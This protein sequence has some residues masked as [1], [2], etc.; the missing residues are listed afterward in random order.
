MLALGA[1]VLGFLGNTF[2]E[3]RERQDAR[4]ALTARAEVPL[5]AVWFELD[6]PVVAP[7]NWRQVTQFAV[8]LETALPE[9]AQEAQEP[10]T[11]SHAACQR[12]RPL[13]EGALD[14]WLRRLSDK[15]IVWTSQPTAPQV[16]LRLTPGAAQ[17]LDQHPPTF[18][19]EVPWL[20]PFA[21][22]GLAASDPEARISAFEGLFHEIDDPIRRLWESATSDR[23]PIRVVYDPSSPERP[24]P[25]I[26]LPPRAPDIVLAALAL[27][28][29]FFAFAMV[30]ASRQLPLRPAALRWP[31]VIC[32]VLATPAWGMALERLP[33]T[34]DYVVDSLQELFL[35]VLQVS[36]P[37]SS[38]ALASDGSAAASVRRPWNLETS[39][40][41]AWLG[42]VR[43]ELASGP[44][45]PS[46]APEPLR[47]ANDESAFAVA[48]ATRL[49]DRLEQQ[50]DADLAELFDGLATSAEE[51][52]LQSGLLFV[53]SAR[54]TLNHPNSPAAASGARSFLLALG[55]KMSGYVADAP[56]SPAVRELWSPL[57]EHP[58]TA[59]AATARLVLDGQ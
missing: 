10:V 35:G 4:A 7:P 52:R 50:G 20:D 42:P 31:F 55:S 58:E 16:D 46:G 15:A 17:W 39:I 23:A 51:G 26:L 12:F 30:R 34:A 6:M 37:P 3:L 49:A 54:R 43:D 2:L 13:P 57:A 40:D 32:L 47:G 14:V 41:A 48:L 45:G 9:P 22:Q 25:V 36:A 8:C 27:P 29:F 56:R 59:I 53:E 1:L 19:W 44:A 18:S 24:V 33:E 21:D 28:A 5:R 38:P 11:S